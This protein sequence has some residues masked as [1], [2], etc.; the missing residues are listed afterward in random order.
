M[1][2][3]MIRIVVVSLLAAAM[4]LGASP[5]V[6]ADGG[7][8]ADA[9]IDISI[10][11]DP[12]VD[13][14]ARGT[15]EVNVKREASSEANTVAMFLSPDPVTYSDSSGKGTVIDISISGES[16][17][18]IVARGTCELNVKVEGSAKV[19]IDA[20][21]EVRLNVEASD[22][23]QVFLDDQSLDNPTQ[24][25]DEPAGYQESVVPVISGV[26]PAAG[27]F[28]FFLIRRRAKNKV[29]NERR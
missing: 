17:V 6:H 22:E 26:F 13:I 1:V 19:S 24:K 5:V 2:K 12:K 4:L 7:D 18:D 16:E 28:A 14:A 27:L 11:G 21:D 8:N 23:S 29:N 9:V 25:P 3:H 20:G 15:C 10:K